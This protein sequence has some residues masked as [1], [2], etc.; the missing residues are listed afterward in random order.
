[1]NRLDQSDLYTS[2]LAT[3][4]ATLYH[5]R[6]GEGDVS[7]LVSQLTEQAN[8]TAGGKFWE[9]QKEEEEQCSHCWWRYRPSSEAVEMTAYMVMVHVLRSEPGLAVE[10]VK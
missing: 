9:L 5:A 1:M 4:A 7:N 2:I 3:H 8:T 10:S 6:M